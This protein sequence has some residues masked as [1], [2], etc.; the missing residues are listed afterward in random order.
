MTDLQRKCLKLHKAYLAGELGDQMMPEDTHPDF[1]SQEER[2]AFFTLPMALNYQRNSYKLWEAATETYQ[3]RATRGAFDV[4]RAAKMSAEELRPLLLKYKV[5]LQPNKHVATWRRIGCGVF[6]NWGSI[7]GLLEAAEFDF[8]K[9]QRL[10][11][12]EHKKDFPYL[13][14]PKIFH[15]WSHILGE[16]C[17]VELKNRQFIQIAPD[18][19]VVQCSIRL[20]LVSEAE[21]K[22]MSRDEIS[23]TWRKVLRGTGLNPI[24]MHSPLW[25]WSRNGFVY[26][27]D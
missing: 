18:T 5:A 2:L 22:T 12:I 20:G 24:D 3:D 17:G 6:E 15:Y 10:V 11:Q 8:L 25:F 16:Y 9:L 27:L 7:G 14:G 26:K 19:H 4:T 21:A 13:S 1:A 23:E